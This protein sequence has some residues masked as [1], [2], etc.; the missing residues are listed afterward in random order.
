MKKIHLSL[1]LTVL[2]GLTFVGCLGLSPQE[3]KS[4]YIQNSSDK[5]LASKFSKYY[6]DGRY[7]VYNTNNITRIYARAIDYDGGCSN[8]QAEY[9]V[10]KY[11]VNDGVFQFYK[12]IIKERNNIYKIYTSRFNKRLQKAR[13]G[14]NLMMFDDTTSRYFL[15]DLLPVIAEYDKDGNLVSIML[16]MVEKGV[17][18]NNF[19]DPQAPATIFLN[20]YL[21]HGADLNTLNF[22]ISEDEWKSNLVQTSK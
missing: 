10:K 15:W 11:L 8:A 16:N 7:R 3:R 18:F 14:R 19:R 1:I 2:V 22:S 5:Y 4:M 21:V 17:M 12:K 20:T 13:S 6:D 9:C